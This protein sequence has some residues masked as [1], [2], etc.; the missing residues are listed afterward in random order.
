ML[1]RSTNHSLVEREKERHSNNNELLQNKKEKK[2]RGFALLFLSTDSPMTFCL[3][4]VRL[5]DP[6]GDWGIKSKDPEEP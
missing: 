2:E 3:L 4:Q 5:E 6:K 1:F